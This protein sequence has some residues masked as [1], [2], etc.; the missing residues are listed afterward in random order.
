MTV[1]EFTAIPVTVPVTVSKTVTEFTAIPVTV[2]VTVTETIATTRT[3]TW[4]EPK[5]TQN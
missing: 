5:Y 1:T 2:P 4:W 3:R